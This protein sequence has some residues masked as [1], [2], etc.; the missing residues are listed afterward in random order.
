MRDVEHRHGVYGG[1]ANF[2]LVWPK[3]SAEPLASTVVSVFILAIVRYNQGIWWYAGE[4]LQTF[5]DAL[6]CI[7]CAEI[8]LMIEEQSVRECRKIIAVRGTIE[9]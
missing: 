4:S 1:H 6:I 3:N 5:I 8:A 7:L 9:V 2:C